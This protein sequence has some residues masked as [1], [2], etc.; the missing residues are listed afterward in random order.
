MYQK[1]LKVI[2]I[3]I[4]NL[5]KIYGPKNLIIESQKSEKIIRI[6]GSSFNPDRTFAKRIIAIEF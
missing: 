4:I 3:N 5:L 6:S 2:F 1:H